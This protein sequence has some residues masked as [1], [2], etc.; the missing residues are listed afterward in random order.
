[1]EKWIGMG[2]YWWINKFIIPNLI[3]VPV[4]YEIMEKLIAKF[5][6]GTKVDY[7]AEM[8]ADYEHEL[9]EDGF[10]PKYCSSIVKRP[11]H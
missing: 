1:M 8:I 5:S 4:I 10:T 6:K 11:V 9:S 7:E 3:I 2:N